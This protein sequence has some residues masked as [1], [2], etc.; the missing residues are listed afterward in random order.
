MS[1][2]RKAFFWIKPWWPVALMTALIAISSSATFGSD[3]TS[4]PLRWFW[5][6][7]FGPV[8][9]ARW[10]FIHF[11]I[12]KTGHFTGYGTLGLAWL[13]AWRMSLPRV[14]FLLRGVLAVM[15]TAFIASCDE[16]HQ[17]FI[18]NRT[19]SPWD[20]LLDTCGAAAMCLLAWGIAHLARPKQMRQPSPDDEHDLVA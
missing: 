17:T 6:A 18:P 7:I 9:D 4:G 14:H 5:Q 10:D 3:H 13:R 8:N 2:E 19:G 12:R 11:L 16:Y 15:G 1:S 20:V